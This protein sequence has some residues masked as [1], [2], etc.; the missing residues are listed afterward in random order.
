MGLRDEDVVPKDEQRADDEEPPTDSAADDFVVDGRI[1][2]LPAVQLEDIEE[3]EA[4]SP[5]KDAEVQSQG[6]GE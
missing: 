4:D 1:V 6:E 3:D 5:E 2:G